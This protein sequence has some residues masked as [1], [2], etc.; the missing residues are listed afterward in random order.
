LTKLSKDF[1]D[2]KVDTKNTREW[3][4]SSE[5]D[6][7]DKNKEN[8][9]RILDGCRKNYKP[10]PSLERHQTNGLGRLVETELAKLNMSYDTNAH[11]RAISKS[12]IEQ[13][14]PKKLDEILKKWMQKNPEEYP[15]ARLSEL[16]KKYG[17]SGIES[18]IKQDKEHDNK[19]DAL[20]FVSFHRFLSQEID[21]EFST[22]DG[23]RRR[24]SVQKENQRKTLNAIRGR[25]PEFE[26][27][28]ALKSRHAIGLG[29]RRVSIDFDKEL[30]SRHTRPIDYKTAKLNQV[31]KNVIQNDKVLASGLS[32]TTNIHIS[33]IYQMGLQALKNDPKLDSKSMMQGN[34]AM[35]RSYCEMIANTL[36]LDGGHSHWEVFK[37]I[38]VIA[39]KMETDQEKL[40]AE[41]PADKRE[42]DYDKTF[43]KTLKKI[44]SDGMVNDGLDYSEHYLRLEKSKMMD[45]HCREDAFSHAVVQLRNGREVATDDRLNLESDRRGQKSVLSK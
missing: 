22:K 43:I 40:Y 12:I 34:E 17:D 24:A 37:A 30:T 26:T 36:C 19:F 38:N 42:K 9:L 45:P 15:V 7:N 1:F 33:G 18:I 41:F 32:S 5:C 16:R 4:R 39:K 25:R 21:K 29:K 35:M 8:I 20:L 31:H 27:P 23:W 3:L 2:G 10:D 13:V 6:L 14:E 44:A 11:M 28:S